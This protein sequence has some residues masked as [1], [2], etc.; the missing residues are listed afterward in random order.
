MLN[1]ADKCTSKMATVA[2]KRAAIKAIHCY[3][4]NL[5]PWSVLLAAVDAAAVGDDTVPDEAEAAKR[6]RLLQNAHAVMHLSLPP[7]PNTLSDWIRNITL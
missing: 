1:G 4:Q 3:P 2:A 5:E 7:A 6:R